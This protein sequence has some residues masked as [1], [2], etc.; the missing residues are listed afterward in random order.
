MRG[1]SIPF[2]K[3]DKTGEVT[4]AV[5]WALILPVAECGTMIVIRGS[6]MARPPVIETNPDIRV[7]L[8]VS[9]VGLTD[10]QFFRLCSDN[11]DLLFE[12]SAEQELIVMS[13]TKPVT[14]RKNAT[15]TARLWNWTQHDGTGVS[16]GSSA[17]F[18]LPNGAKRSP[19]GAW[20]ANS[21]WKCLTKEEQE[22]LHEI[23]PDFVI[24]LRSR[25]DVLSDLE[26][27]MEEYIINGARLGWL[28]DPTENRAT[29]YR[30]GEAP[31]RMDQPTILTGDPV[32]PGFKFDFR[33]IL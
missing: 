14:D 28:L 18:S 1:H 13:P 5:I 19:D 27:K 10:D 2:Y 26:K 31:E 17:L 12:M 6:T 4:R 15:I 25:S 30:A 20:I 8:D 3:E 29:I 9:S 22:E 11:R 21:R 23:C 24:E 32:L 33:E 16:F 7:T